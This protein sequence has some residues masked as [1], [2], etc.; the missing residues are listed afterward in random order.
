M[1]P[2]PGRCIKT[3]L[4]HILGLSLKEAYLLTL[5]LLNTGQASSLAHIQGTA[6]V[7]SGDVDQCMPSVHSLS[8]QL[9]GTPRPEP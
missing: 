6:D 8:L 7:F 1:L 3:R 4:K 2:P 5:E 9:I